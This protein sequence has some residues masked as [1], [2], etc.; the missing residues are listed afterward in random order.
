MAFLWQVAFAGHRPHSSPAAQ[1]KQEP[2][3]G[4]PREPGAAPGDLGLPPR[5]DDA[6]SQSDAA[7]PR[8]VSR[9]GWLAVIT[10]GLLIRR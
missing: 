3:P 8:S 9:T 7:F 5:Q 10:D 4:D 1:R 6:R 2:A